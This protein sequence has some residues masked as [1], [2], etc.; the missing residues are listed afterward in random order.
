MHTRFRCVI[1]LDGCVAISGSD[2]EWRE[3]RGLVVRPDAE[4]S[5]DCN[6]ASGVMLAWCL[7]GVRSSRFV[8]RCLPNPQYLLKA[9]LDFLMMSGLLFIFFLVFEHLQL[10]PP[11]AIVVARAPGR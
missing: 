1:A 10:A 4:H 8:K 2:R 3:T 7:A 5:F 9:H 11:M 6:G